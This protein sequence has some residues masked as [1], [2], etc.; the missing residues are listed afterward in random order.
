M[1]E[2]PLSLI[3]ALKL[4]RCP[5]AVEGFCSELESN[6]TVLLF[7]RNDDSAIKTQGNEN[8]SLVPALH[9]LRQENTDIAWHFYRGAPLVLL[10]IV[11]EEKSTTKRSV[12]KC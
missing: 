11:L 12:S 4:K 1:T 10:E 8:A 5:L 3:K 7:T 9:P 2:D 6:P